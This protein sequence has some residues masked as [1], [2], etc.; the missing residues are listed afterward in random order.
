MP[1][2]SS[3]SLT[4]PTPWR[5]LIAASALARRESRGVHRRSDFPAPD[6]DLD[7]RHNVVSA[8]GAIRLERWPAARRTPLNEDLT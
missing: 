1:S 4:I 2:I 3:D 6:P 7:L 8:D 5:S